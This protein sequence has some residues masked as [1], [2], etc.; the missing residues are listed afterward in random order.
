MAFSG[1]ANPDGLAT[2]AHFEYGLD[3][4]YLGGGPVV[5]SQSTPNQ[6]IGSDFA[7]H[8]VSA[9][10]SGLNPNTRYHVR[11]VATNN[12]GTSVMKEPA[13]GVKTGETTNAREAK[14]ASW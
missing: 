1:S 9:S 3:P 6:T 11:L 5:Y 2:T 4:A 8:A 7:N 14:V 13:R 12:A 10:V